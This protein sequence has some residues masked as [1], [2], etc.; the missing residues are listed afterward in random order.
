MIARHENLL[1]RAQRWSAFGLAAAMSLG[2]AAALA[3]AGA[4]PVLPYSALELCVLGAAFYAIERRATRWERLT[5]A[6]DRVIVE[7]AV[8]E[9]TQRREF[10]R[11]WLKIEMAT[12]GS[13]RDPQLTLRFAGEAMP[14]G[15][16]L[17][18]A[19]RIEVAR[20]LMRLT[21]SR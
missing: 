13:A 5:V 17:P 2:V 6:G 8:G 21:A 1:P 11:W 20:A 12:S 3:L 15:R 9:R 14:F 10:N 16:A 7:R 19:R 4:W 18:P